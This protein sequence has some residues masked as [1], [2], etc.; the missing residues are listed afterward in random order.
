MVDLAMEYWTEAVGQSLEEHRVSASPDQ[1]SKIAAD[2]IGAHENHGMAFPSPF[3]PSP[4]QHELDEAQRLLAAEQA[5]VT[6]RECDG[7][8]ILVTLGPHHSGISTC[9]KCG[10]DRRHA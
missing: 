9:W 6:C 4:A 8:G 3:G 1:I 7:V 5:K 2:M 10:G